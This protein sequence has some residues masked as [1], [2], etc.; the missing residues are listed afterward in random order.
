MKALTCEMCGSTNLIKSEGVFVCQHCGTKYSVEEAKKM[1]VEGTVSVKGT[2]VVDNSAQ[3]ENYLVMAINASQAGNYSEA[4]SYCNKIIEI[5]PKHSRAWQLKGTSAGWQSTLANLRLEECM[6]CFDN[7]LEFATEDETET[8]KEY[9]SNDAKSLSLAIINLSCNHFSE[10]PQQDTQ[11]IVD[12]NWGWI[13]SGMS[14]IIKT[15]GENPTSLKQKIA[16]IIGNTAINTYN[17]LRNNY[18]NESHPSEYEWQ[19]YR[20]GG[21]G[22]LWL[23]RTVVLISEVSDNE[24]ISYYKKMINMQEEIARSCSWTYSNGG[25]VVEYTLTETA[26]QYRIDEIMEWHQSLKEL[27]PDYVIP[28]RPSASTSSGGCYI[29][30]AVYGSYDCP[31]VWTLRRFRDYTLAET[32]FGRAFI[33]VYYATSPTLVRWFGKSALFNKMWRTPLDKLVA[34]L[35]TKG[36]QNTPYSD[37]NR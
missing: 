36:V 27:N 18:I 8:I 33:K 11:T 12:E 30:T 16:E 23:L 25:Y 29:A 26:K 4:E 28:T 31:E 15:C 14:S 24:K 19:K 9:V 6:H 37:R 35:N 13:A 1:M 3:L 5:D 2:V 34:T 21:D 22:C 7:A 32:A 17:K 10:F 20:D